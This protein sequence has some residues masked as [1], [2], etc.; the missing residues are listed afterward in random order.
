MRR[1]RTSSPARRL[2]STTTRKAGSCRRT[3]LSTARG[4]SPR[5]PP[6][7]SAT[8]SHWW[9]RPG[10][11]TS[12]RGA[13]AAAHDR[14]SVGRGA[15]G[16]ALRG[17]GLLDLFGA[18]H[19]PPSPPR[20]S[21]RSRSSSRTAQPQQ[22]QAAGSG[23]AASAFCRACVLYYSADGRVAAAKLHTLLLCRGHLL[24]VEPPFTMAPMPGLAAPPT[25]IPGQ[26]SR[27]PE[28]GNGTAAAARIGG[29]RSLR[30]VLGAEGTLAS[31]LALRSVS[32][33]RHLPAVDPASAAAASGDK[34][35]S[36]GG[37]SSSDV[38]AYREACGAM[39]L[40]GLSAEQRVGVWRAVA[41]VL[42]LG[43]VNRHHALTG[44]PG[45]SSGDL[46]VADPDDETAPDEDG[47]TSN[48]GPPE[49]L[50]HAA[51]LLGCSAE[52]MWRA[53]SGSGGASSR[54]GPR[55]SSGSPGGGAPAPGH[56]LVARA[57]ALALHICVKIFEW[58][59]EQI[60]TSLA[61]TLARRASQGRSPGSTPRAENLD[62]S[63]LTYLAVLEA[64]PPAPPLESAAQGSAAAN[65]TGGSGWW[66]A[67][68]ARCDGGLESLLQT[69][70]AEAI[71]E[72]MCD[73][74]YSNLVEQPKQDGIANY[75]PPALPGEHCRSLLTL[76]GAPG[77]VLPLLIEHEGAVATS[78][79]PNAAQESE[80]QLIRSLSAR[81]TKA[82]HGG[83]A[84]GNGGARLHGSGFVLAHFH[85]EVAYDSSRL[86]A[87][88]RRSAEP[89]EALLLCLQ[90]STIPGIRGLFSEKGARG[91]SRRGAAGSSTSAVATCASRL[92]TM[93]DLLSSAA[94]THTTLCLLPNQNGARRVFDAKLVGRQ[95]DGF[96]VPKLA[97]AMGTGYAE[98]M[99]VRRFVGRYRCLAPINSRR[100][101]QAFLLVGGSSA[102]EVRQG[103]EALLQTL[104]MRPGDYQ[105]GRGFVFLKG[106]QLSQLEAMRSVRLLTAAG[107][108]AAAVRGLRVRA[109]LRRVRGGGGGGARRFAAL[110]PSEVRAALSPPNA[111]RRRRHEVPAAESRRVM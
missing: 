80:K 67:A 16:A 86:S 62:L 44:S 61:S 31:E 30:A 71:Y 29:A 91:R 65:V 38:A 17:C 35:S 82:A 51:R 108:I 56:V 90:A 110:D 87:G 39:E 84:G 23:H 100:M 43:C 22:Q 103:C 8:A 6:R 27:W 83:G 59:S 104:P 69:Y 21:S 99:E 24:P 94:H 57:D 102:E 72:R 109:T 45:S 46:M 54:G 107:P 106:G 75:S 33:S 2:K 95:L 85:G 26:Q 105:L 55:G 48:G 20:S 25:P 89:P 9:A 18:T 92:S 41:A 47:A 101:H 28:S 97:A 60:N 64:P 13:H 50:S 12:S 19:G 34:G 40:A 32:S 10:G 63:H 42:H 93:V 15:R 81:V 76:L 68:G 11:K 5:S 74:L 98:R 77:G 7:V 14:L 36:S 66:A 52:S 49:A 79:P 88:L 73:A 4:R 96:G 37:G 58:L 3:S 78:A 53:L 70:A 111:P 1:C